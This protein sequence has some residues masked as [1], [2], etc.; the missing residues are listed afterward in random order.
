MSFQ[1]EFIDYTKYLNVYYRNL[2]KSCVSFN[3]SA[4]N[5]RNLTTRADITSAD[6][7]IKHLLWTI[8]SDYKGE[9]NYRNYTIAMILIFIAISV[10]VM[11]ILLFGIMLPF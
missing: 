2:N 5:N 9:P 10:V 3:L 11:H 1:S 4:L 7:N 6:A 8:T